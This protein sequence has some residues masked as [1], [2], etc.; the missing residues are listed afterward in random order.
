MKRTVILTG[1]PAPNGYIDLWSQIFILDKG[2]RLGKNISMYRRSFFDSD[3]MG[4]KFEIKRGAKEDIDNRIKDIIIIY[5][6]Y[7]FK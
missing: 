6:S 2:Q 1:T 7:K 4:Y 3:F 5:V